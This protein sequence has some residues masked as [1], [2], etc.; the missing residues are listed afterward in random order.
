V[1][2]MKVDRDKA[3][4]AVFAGTTYYFCSE[5]CRRAFEANEAEHAPGDTRAEHKHPAH[6]HH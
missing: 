4:T 6:T 3:L 1:C 2:G 5:H